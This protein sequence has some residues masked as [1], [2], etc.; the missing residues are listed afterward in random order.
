MQENW[1]GIVGRFAASVSCMPGDTMLT[2][3]AA[4]WD[5]EEEKID[6]Q[7]VRVVWV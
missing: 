6:M 1:L 4:R 7:K 2:V 3:G 5:V